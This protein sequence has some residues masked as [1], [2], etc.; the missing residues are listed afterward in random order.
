MES[1][2]TVLIDIIPKIKSYL[3]SETD[4]KS[5]SD[6]ITKN[7]NIFVVNLYNVSTIT[8]EDIRLLYATIE[9]NIDVDDQTLISIFSYIGYKFEQNIKEEVSSSLF[10]NESSATDEMTFNLY[11]MFF[12]TL[13][14]YLR[15]KRINVLVNDES[16]SDISINY[17]TSDIASVFD[18]NTEPEIREIPFNMKYMIQ[19]VSKNID[20]LRF[21]KKYLD[22]AYL[23]R[24]IGIPI[25]KKKLNM[26]Y[27]Y[28]Y[29]VDGLS[30]PIVIKDFLDVKYV[31]LEETGKTYKNSFSE[32]KNNSL[33]D[34]GKVIIP[35]LKNKYLYSYIFLS[36]H[37][38]KDLFPDLI[39]E[40][41]IFF[42]DC[43][44]TNKIEVHEPSSWKDDV[45]IKTLPCEHQIKLID[46]MKIDI[47]Y[48][49]KINNF[50]REYV[51]YED[52]LAYCNV[53]GMNVPTFNLDAADVIKNNVVVSTFNKSI[54]LSEPYSYFVHSQRFIF[55]IIMSFDNIMKSQTWVM[56]YNINRLILNFLIDINSKRQKYEKKFN[57]EIKKGVFFL[58]L[59]A[60]LFDIHVSSTELFYSSKI[61][62]LNYIVVLV[63]VLNSSADF[64][65]SYMNAKKKQIDETSIKYALS[66]IIYD[67]LLKTKICEKGFLNTITLLTDVY[68]SIMPEELNVHFNRILIELKK[69]I[70]IKRSEKQPSYDVEVKILDPPLTK[71]KFFNNCSIIVKTMTLPDIKKKVNKNIE[72]PTYTFKFNEKMFLQFKSLTTDEELKVLIRYND[73][74]A[75][76]LVIFPTHL[77]IEIER[78]KLIIALKTLFTNNVLKYYYSVPSLYV[79][80][81]GDPFPFDDELID[82]FHVQHK[83]N[84]YNLL[85][86]YM[87]PNSDVFVYFNKS[88]KREKLE[89]SFY[90]FLHNYVGDVSSWIDKNITRIREL[91]V[92]NFNN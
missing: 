8:E 9:Q 39:H 5:Y 32:D 41:E 66:V 51:Y 42:R 33:I 55:N 4:T 83:V 11:N 15:Q 31:Y 71:I 28:L 65:I 53:C 72:R 44:Q 88:L 17:R 50:A 67:F 30:I 70:S 80:R 3:L 23:C 63:I 16:N 47:D 35:K 54:F 7:K 25:S 59:S 49:N 6:F 27:I 36:N 43:K 13:D 24:H 74:N 29:K 81:F 40:K 58:R 56:K 20:R 26:R 91:Y 46:A 45:T 68:T 18:S 75:T 38:L 85:R 61:L 21:S 52:G 77:K 84:C 14:M 79:F 86:Y 10:I 62:N 2:E 37:Y 76:K 90:M 12:N 64:I 73:T 19:Y 69:L 87:L 89:Y 34:W 60:N 78:K 22:F 92:I 57:D 1:K 82:F 48:F